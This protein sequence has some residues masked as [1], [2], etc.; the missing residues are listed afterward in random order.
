MFYPIQ[1]NTML[2]VGYQSNKQCQNCNK[3]TQYL[4]TQSYLLLYYFIQVDYDPV[5]N[6]IL[7]QTDLL[8]L[9]LINILHK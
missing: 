1:N 5:F 4:N 8:M 9:N 6:F 2:L 7:T 3:H